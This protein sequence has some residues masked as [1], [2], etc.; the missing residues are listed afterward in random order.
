MFFVGILERRLHNMEQEQKE[1]NT[2]LD[3]LFQ[4]FV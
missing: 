4:H 1:I 3:I 2:L